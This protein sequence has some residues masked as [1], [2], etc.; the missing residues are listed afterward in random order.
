[1]D[2]VQLFHL[3]GALLNNAVACYNQMIPELTSIH[4]QSLGLPD[5]AAK[6]SVLLNYNMNHHV[7]T[8][9]GVSKDSYAYSDACAKLGEGQG[10]ASSPS[11]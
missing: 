3:N 7:K 6:C 10:K 4:L 2:S 1:M 11:N 5:N 8:T 9:A